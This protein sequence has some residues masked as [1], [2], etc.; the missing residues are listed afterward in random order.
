MRYKDTFCW[1]CIDYENKSGHQKSMVRIIVCASF[2]SLNLGL[3]VDALKIVQVKVP[4]AALSGHSV[5]LECVFALEG[6][7]LYAVKWYRGADEFYRYVPA[8]EPRATVFN[9]NGIEVDVSISAVCLFAPSR[10]CARAAPL[11]FPL[12]SLCTNRIFLKRSIIRRPAGFVLR[13][14]GKQTPSVSAPCTNFFQEF[15]ATTW[16]AIHYALSK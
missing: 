6:D 10:V 4:P 7:S 2:L 15:L 3:P 16:A 12:R 13:A 8:E 1:L 5:L 14:L 11:L 9:L